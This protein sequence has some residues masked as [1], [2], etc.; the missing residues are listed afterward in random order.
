LS[1]TEDWV[2]PASMRI[3]TARSFTKNLLELE[4]ESTQV[5]EY[6]PT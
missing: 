4:N 1:A 2:V 6:R 3:F 5:L